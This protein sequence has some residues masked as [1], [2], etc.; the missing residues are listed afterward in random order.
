VRTRGGLLAE[1]QT[2]DALLAG[3]AA[4][5]A[6]GFRELETYTPFPV[7]GVEARLAPRPSRL[8]KFIFAGGLL[9]AILCYGIQWYADVWVWPMRI[10]G[11]PVHAVPAFIPATFEATVLGAALAAFV[12]LL[13]ALRLPELWHPVFE[14][15]G[16]E[17]ASVDRFWLAVGERDPLFDAERTRAALA[18]L[19]PLRVLPI[20][21]AES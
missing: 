13:V 12:G 9:G 19:D 14:V 3:T 17:R 20:P 6:L 1:F 10:G 15:D 21:E 16:F 7:P 4:L 11:R 5:H 18:A 8:P 2:A